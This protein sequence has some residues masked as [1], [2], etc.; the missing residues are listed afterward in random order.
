MHTVEETIDIAVPVRT[1]YNQW[2]QFKGFPRFM[3]TVRKVEHIRP[4]VILWVMGVGPV[5][6]ELLIEIV[7]QEPDSHVTWR[8]LGRRPAHQGEATFRSTA[9]G[10]TAVTVRMRLDPRGVPGVVTGIPGVAGRLVR[11]ELGHFKKYIEGLGEE[12]GAWRGTIRNGQV[13]PADQEPS[14]SR[15]AS[16]PVG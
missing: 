6:R 16:W 4:A 7:E 8:G 12:D 3:T 11:S 14:R 13:R 15:V 2:T 1:A 10:G 9:T 5:R